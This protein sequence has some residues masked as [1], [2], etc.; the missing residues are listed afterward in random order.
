VGAGAVAVAVA[1]RAAGLRARGGLWARENLRSFRIYALPA[2][3]PRY[4]VRDRAGDRDRLNEEAAGQ[5]TG[6]FPSLR[7]T[8]VQLA[9]TC[10]HHVFA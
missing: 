8:G 4:P 9:F 5:K 1:G 10:S 2:T 3:Y 7:F 6:C